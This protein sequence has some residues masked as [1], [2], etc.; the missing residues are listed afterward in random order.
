MGTIQ[1]LK[2]ED[3]TV[4]ELMKPIRESKEAKKDAMKKAISTSVDETTG[5]I[6]NQTEQ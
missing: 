3:T 5:E 6:F 1:A 4:D 2:D